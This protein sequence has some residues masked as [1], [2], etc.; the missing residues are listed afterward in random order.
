[1]HT[2]S[3]I[4][5]TLIAG[6]FFAGCGNRAGM[7]SQQSPSSM[8]QE[9]DAQATTLPPSTGDVDQDF[10]EIEASLDSMNTDVDF[11]SVSEAELTEQ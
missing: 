1:M 9:S 11:P 10:R 2:F 8:A 6:V 7:S 5:V 3:V 4:T